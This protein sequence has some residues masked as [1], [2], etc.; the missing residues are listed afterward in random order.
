M[1]SFLVG[2]YIL[3]PIKWAKNEKKVH[4]N[5]TSASNAE[6][7]SGSVGRSMILRSLLNIALFLFD[8]ST[9]MYYVVIIDKENFISSR[10]CNTCK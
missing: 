6:K 2:A 9:L 1:S 7:I 3:H 8:F 4:N 5:T 10:L